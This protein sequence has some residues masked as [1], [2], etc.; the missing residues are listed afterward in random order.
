VRRHHPNYAID[1][2]EES[3]PTQVPRQQVQAVQ[4]QKDLPLLH[5]EQFLAQQMHQHNSNN[6]FDLFKGGQ[7]RE[8]M[9]KSDFDERLEKMMKEEIKIGQQYFTEFDDGGGGSS[10]QQQEEEE[11]PEVGTSSASGNIMNNMNIKGRDGMGIMG[12]N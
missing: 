2:H 3:P 9:S 6:D 1:S 8:E 5:L 11:P 12:T 10:L 4:P 7:M